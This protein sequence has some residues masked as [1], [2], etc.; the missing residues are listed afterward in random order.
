MNL[1]IFFFPLTLSRIKK[2]QMSQLS[3]KTLYFSL[4]Y[5]VTLVLFGCGSEVRHINS[6]VCLVK[7]GST[8]KQVMDV[9]GPPNIKTTTED[10]ELWTYYTAKES[11]M[12]RT[13]G[14]GLIFGTTT[15]DVVH[16]TFTGDVVSNRQ[17]RHANE[18]EFQKFKND[19][20]L[21][22]N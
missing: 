8:T 11:P 14:L 15:Y 20:Q 7:P 3:R 22:E 12:K 1:D 10:G 18:K 6:D 9:L 17:Y 13:P 2:A 21:E 16:V 19:C 4:I 5:L